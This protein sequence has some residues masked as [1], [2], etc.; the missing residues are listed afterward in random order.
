MF[1][2]FTQTE[3]INPFSLF[4]IVQQSRLMQKLSQSMSR[5]VTFFITHLCSPFPET[6]ALADLQL[7]TVGRDA[8]Q[9]DWKV[10]EGGPSGYLLTWEGQQSSATG[11]RSTVYLPP[12][13]QTTRLT[14]LPPTARVCVSPIYN[15]GRGDGLCC[16][17]NFHS[18][19]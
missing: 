7:T 13:S 14:N 9:V 10:S 19:T 17:A 18:G 4:S 6:P 11:Q 16:T 3:Q 2:Y 5:E 1:I 8:V 12:D 15:K